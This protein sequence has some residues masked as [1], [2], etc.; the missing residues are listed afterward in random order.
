MARNHGMPA[1]RAGIYYDQIIRHEADLH[2]L[3]RYIRD[4]PRN[5]ALR[6]F[7]RYSVYA[8]V[9][10]ILTTGTHDDR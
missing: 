8:A 10:R 2:R 1:N 4:K 7:R 9:R 3:R 5:D 6:N